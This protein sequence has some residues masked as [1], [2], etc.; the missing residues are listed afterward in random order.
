MALWGFL[1]L[2]S[3]NFKSF[4]VNPHV[5]ENGE[6]HETI[7]HGLGLLYRNCQGNYKLLVTAVIV[8]AGVGLELLFL[9]LLQ[10]YMFNIMSAMDP[11]KWI[12]YRNG[13]IKFTA[14][15][16]SL[17]V[18][19]FFTIASSV[20]FSPRLFEISDFWL[21]L[22]S[23]P[24]LEIF[25]SPKK[26][27]HKF[28]PRFSAPPG[29]LHR[30]H[31]IKTPLKTGILPRMI[32]N[33]QYIF[34]GSSAERIVDNLKVRALKSIMWK[35]GAYFDH[36]TF[37]KARLISNIAINSEALKPVSQI[38]GGLPSEVRMAKGS[39]ILGPGPGWDGTWVSSSGMGP[40][41]NIWSCLPPISLFQSPITKICK[42][43]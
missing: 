7:P 31:R 33:F 25:G 14:F 11:A 16:I 12:E 32:A 4:Q 10:G 13:V 8:S 29:V 2:S 30:L 1:K 19:C 15:S 23:V 21:S 39:E 27:D 9:V 6:S 42:F 37:G 43:F 35:G 40:G 34:Y 24:K 3:I 41:F 36:P 22:I 28:F 26:L 17:G 38:I 5:H 20:S 18:F